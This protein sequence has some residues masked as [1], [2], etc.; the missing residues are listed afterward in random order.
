VVHAERPANGADAS[1]EANALS[2]V[3]C[4]V[5]PA[6]AVKTAEVH[7]LTVSRESESDATWAERRLVTARKDSIGGHR[8]TISIRSKASDG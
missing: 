1:S 5:L 6:A 7:K 8:S 2:Q 3:V 4:Q